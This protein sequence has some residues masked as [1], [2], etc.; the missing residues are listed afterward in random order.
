[1]LVLVLAWVTG[2]DA[3]KPAVEQ[4][5]KSA[6]PPVAPPER[7]PAPPGPMLPDDPLPGR[8]KNPDP[9]P[10][11]QSAKSAKAIAA[12]DK[13]T[14]FVSPEEWEVN[15]S[16]TKDLDQAIKLVSDLDHV[17]ALELGEKASDAHLAACSRFKE[18]RKLTINFNENVTDAGLA[19][20][21]SFSHVQHL[22]LMNL[23]QAT[24][25]G[26]ASVA[27]MSELESLNVH[28][29]QFGEAGAKHFAGLRKLKVLEAG[30]CALTLAAVAHFANM[31]ELC[32][33][34]LANNEELT[35]DSLKHL[36][37]MTKLEKLNLDSAKIG[38]AGLQYIAD[39]TRLTE[40]NLARTDVGDAG[41]KRL[42]KM[43][44]L[45]HLD[46]SR[47]RITDAGLEALSG[48]KQLAF[49]DISGT[50]IK[51]NGLKHLAGCKE[52]TTLEVGYMT[53]FTGE[54]L[55]HLAGCPK[56]TS[57]NLSWTGLTDAG[58][59]DIKA[60]EQLTHL[61]L[62]P[63]GHVSGFTEAFWRDP[64]PERFSDKGLKHIGEMTNL[65][66][67]YLSGSGLTDDGLAH[68][69]GL[70]KL[71]TLSLGV[72]PNIKGPGL[73]QL[74]D[75]PL[76]EGLRLAETGVTDDTLKHVAVLK[77]LKHL[78]L[79]RTAKPTAVGQLKGM[80]QLETVYVPKD[81]SPDEVEALKK[82]FP[83]ADVYPGD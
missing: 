77:Q 57:I 43:T 22:S 31:T 64:H 46:L 5:E 48:M 20:L 23:K 68:L 83:K 37:G 66:W 71:K 81:W 28:G 51:G 65:E 67:L 30:Y 74:K 50:A 78:G 35:D 63:Y 26:F 34:N 19:H 11:G 14:V 42:A 69:K 1:V 16:F 60:L 13:L 53:H 15:L 36:A 33:L 72:L 10:K 32:E 6:P 49:L 3:K 25:G 39:L 59:A 58:L 82:A 55:N 24:A 61:D 27:G 40:L 47:T 80:T 70:K 8:S 45:A 76:L 73:E 56:L 75:L 62:P 21:K 17:Y 44:N 18:I 2:C 9:K 41:L 38:D 7:V 79:P 29:N 54:G 4:T 12:L 52:L